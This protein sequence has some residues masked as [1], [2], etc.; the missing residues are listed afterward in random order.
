MA[1]KV[2]QAAKAP[3]HSP[4]LGEV[5]SWLRNSTT[6]ERNAKKFTQTQIY[7]RWSLHERSLARNDRDSNLAF[8][9]LSNDEKKNRVIDWEKG[10]RLLSIDQCSVIESFYRLPSGSLSHFRS[11]DDPA[12]RALLASRQSL[13]QAVSEL[14]KY[15]PSRPSSGGDPRIASS[16][17]VSWRANTNLRQNLPA[18]I[19]RDRECWEIWGLVSQNPLV[20]LIG[21]GGIGKTLLAERIGTDH[22]RDFLDGVWFADLTKALGT[23]NLATLV[24]LAV[25]VTL[26]GDVPAHDALA[27]AL[28]GKRLLLILD[29]CEHVIDAVANLVETLLNALPG[30]KILATSRQQIGLNRELS[31]PVGELSFPGEDIPIDHVTDV[32]RFGAARLFAAY[33]GDSL[34]V[35]D[36]N[37]HILASICRL[38]NGVPLSL[39][40]AAF[41]VRELGLIGLHDELT[42]HILQPLERR[43][44]TIAERQR[45][46][47]AALD[48]SYHLLSSH[49]QS[50]F[51]SLAIFEG[52]FTLQAV[53]EVVANQEQVETA[54]IEPFTK[55]VALHLVSRE[56]TGEHERYR[57]HETTREYVSAKLSDCSERNAL[58]RRHAAWVLRRMQ[59]CF[60]DWTQLGDQEFFDCYAAELP[61]L[62]AAIRYCFASDGDPQT[63]V[64]L[65]ASSNELWWLLSLFE[66]QKQHID[67]AGKHTTLAT[68][69]P[70]RAALAYGESW[71]FADSDPIRSIRA[72]KQALR[73]F[74]TISDRMGVAASLRLLYGRYA[75][76]GRRS[77]AEKIYPELDQLLADLGRPRPLV[78]H[79][80]STGT[81]CINDAN[82][83]GALRHFTMAFELARESGIQESICLASSGR[84]EALWMQ[85]RLDEALVEAS[86]SVVEARRHRFT[87]RR[88]LG[89]ALCVL[90]GI[91]V[92]AN[93]RDRVDWVAR[94]L[95]ELALEYSLSYKLLDS[96]SLRATQLRKH[97]LAALVIGHAATLFQRKNTKRDPNQARL[98]DK[99]RRILQPQM[100]GAVLQKLFAEGAALPER[101]VLLMI[102][103]EC[104]AVVK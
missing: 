59:T 91:L 80:Q 50:I 83:P 98:A 32:M 52:G 93:D 35:R 96:F 39:E 31:Y 7:D 56:H 60:D 64:A 36:A 37:A 90:L 81:N 88:N 87:N 27:S 13:E 23:E 54:V 17:T 26:R 102:K 92:E 89:L 4:L 97:E 49:E 34:V 78:S 47:E 86:Y 5:L 15:V 85:N 29:N 21:G 95:I 8:P 41:R 68:P 1:K 57:L 70:V 43:R 103:A 99:A 48:W 61:N 9:Q 12:V 55:L 38:L 79:Y 73:L 100:N 28:A 10:R 74:R 11:Q 104:A 77:D 82:A 44:T 65:V 40:I 101:S 16:A 53:R 75:R 24:S 20:T 3:G 45:S 33:A 14:Q 72:A 94:D 46:V 62:R 63:G 66:E 6:N 18:L 58:S 71:F 42:A 25:G 30:I 22:T 84:A 69:A 76:Q 51:R 19:H 67:T 2:D